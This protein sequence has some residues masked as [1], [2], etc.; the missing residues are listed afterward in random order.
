MDDILTISRA[1]SD[2]L[3]LTVEAVDVGQLVQRAAESAGPVARG[4]GVELLAERRGAPPKSA[5]DRRLLAQLLDNLVSNAVKFTPS[6][7]SV[8]IHACAPDEEI[9]SR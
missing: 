9:A 4:K 5:G 1:D 6:G 8:T 2:R 7:G 3:K